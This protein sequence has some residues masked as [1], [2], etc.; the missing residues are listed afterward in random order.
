MVYFLIQTPVLKFVGVLFAICIM[1]PFCVWCLFLFH[2]SSMFVIFFFLSS[3]QNHINTER[4]S[5]NSALK[6]KMAAFK[7]DRNIGKNNKIEKLLILEMGEII[8]NEKHTKY[9]VDSLFP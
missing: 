2:G 1:Y 6:P 8:K 7:N 4:K 3:V 5:S 9:L